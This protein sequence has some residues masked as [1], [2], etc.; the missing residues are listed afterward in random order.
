MHEPGRQR[1]TA[2]RIWRLGRY[3]IAL[4]LIG[5]LAAGLSMRFASG[6]TALLGAPP[7]TMAISPDGNSA[8]VSVPSLS[9]LVPVDLTSTSAG[10]PIKL[11]AANAFSTGMA[12]SPDGTTVWITF[13]QAREI[14]PLNLGNDSFGKPISVDLAASRAS[15]RW[16]I[17][18]SP[19]GKTAWVTDSSGNEIESVDIANDVAGS[20]ITVGPVVPPGNSSAGLADAVSP[21]GTTVWVVELQSESLVPVSTESDT[22]GSAVQ[23]PGLLNFLSFADGDSQNLLVATQSGLKTVDLATGVSS[24]SASP[25]LQPT[26]AVLAA[27]SGSKRVWAIDSQS[28][29]LESWAVGSPT[30]DKSAPLATPET[31]LSPTAAPP[32]AV[33][34]DCPSTTEW[35]ATRTSLSQRFS[36]SN[37]DVTT[38]CQRSTNATTWVWVTTGSPSNQTPGIVATLTCAKDDNACISGDGNLP[39]S[40]WAQQT[41]P[42]QGA[43]EVITTA[44]ITPNGD[45]GPLLQIDPFSQGPPA[46][47]VF[48]PSTNEFVQEGTS[49]SSS[50]TQASASATS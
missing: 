17:A 14:A 45:I 48:D 2:S 12:Y 15:A 44:G 31:T 11:P 33:V 16:N 32:P 28:G 21:D 1:V 30:A 34:V 40:A 39:T 18:L 3:G 29:D 10:S 43:L 50:T 13:P 19:D 36:S 42:V 26:S 37:T 7:Q 22:V 46:T 20:P 4:C 5:G 35:L 27:S 49:A 25:S 23:V 24:P 6:S 41:L 38:I 47:Y 9:E 8:L